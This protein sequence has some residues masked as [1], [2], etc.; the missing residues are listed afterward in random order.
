MQAPPEYLMDKFPEEIEYLSGFRVA[1][2]FLI[3]SLEE[4]DKYLIKNP[5]KRHKV[6]P[7]M[8]KRLIELQAARDKAFIESTQKGYK[9][10]HAMS[11]E[12]RVDQREKAA[13]KLA[14]K[15]KT[16]PD[17]SEAEISLVETS[18]AKSKNFLTKYEWL[19]WA[20]K[21]LISEHLT[22]NLTKVVVC[23]LKVS[24]F[25][26]MA[27]GN[28][29][30]VWDTCDKGFI[31]NEYFVQLMLYQTVL[32]ILEVPSESMRLPEMYPGI[33]GID[34]N[35]TGFERSG[36]RG[37]EDFVEVRVP[38]SEVSVSS[39]DASDPSLDASVSSLDAS[40]VF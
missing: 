3:M 30:R 39:L 14:C 6:L 32:A 8:I 38:S 31:Y 7:R 25:L 36:L 17:P 35:S 13:V 11:V 5:T 15:L 28:P 10:M 22:L 29:R 20:S 40:I 19:L 24:N 33:Y 16:Y 34:T 1:G 27:L 21:N 4:A 23:M 9:Y 37:I 18:E 26:E 2:E 12:S